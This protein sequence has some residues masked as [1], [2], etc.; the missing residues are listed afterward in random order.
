MAKNEIERF[1][2]VTV[3]R[4]AIKLAEYNPRYIDDGAKK[5]LKKGMKKLGLLTPLIWNRKTGVL[6]SGHQRLAIIDELKKYP[7]KGDYE[8]QVAAVDLTEA[9]EREANVAINN[10][11]MMGDFDFDALRELASFNGVDVDAFGFA[12]SD[13]DLIFGADGGKM[14][15]ILGDTPEVQNAKGK[16]AGIKEERKRMNDK[17]PPKI[18]RLIILSLCAKM[19]M[20]E[21]RFLKKWACQS[22][23]N[24]SRLTSCSG[25]VSRL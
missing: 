5:R 3:K 8:I 24:L 19:Q 23:R 20:N 12:E 18:Q 21:R 2:V 10:Q 7:S 25:C 16:L 17:K 4:S 9:E 15:G 1:E 11:S 22:R 6:V 13:L 14:A